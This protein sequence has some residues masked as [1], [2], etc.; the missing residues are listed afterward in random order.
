[1]SLLDRSRGYGEIFGGS[2]NARYEQDGRLFDA[3]GEEIT[4]APK[5]G[6]KKAVT[7]TDVQLAANLEAIE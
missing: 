6:R 2:D 4:D 3:S 5:R 7:D 1:M